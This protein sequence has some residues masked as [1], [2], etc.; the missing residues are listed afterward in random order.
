[1]IDPMTGRNVTSGF[2]W[3]RTARE[4]YDMFQLKLNLQHDCYGW[5]RIGRTFD[6][7]QTFYRG[8][9][10]EVLSGYVDGKQLAEIRLDELTRAEKATDALIFEFADAISISDYL[11]DEPK[12]EL[13][14]VREASAVAAAPDGFVS[15]GFEPTW[16]P[17]EFS[18]LCD[19]LFL[20]RWHGADPDGVL[21]A[22]HFKRLNRNGLF[23]APG[24]A[25]E[26][27]S[28]YLSFEWAE[29]PLSDTPDECGAYVIVEVFA[30]T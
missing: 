10:R 25:S 23:W 21:L 20:P 26:F 11:S 2:F 30:P 7:V 18:A 22:E 17:G 24:H 6:E 28:H 16:F 13:I 14:W 12:Y 3:V 5:P 19:S 9:N 27:L 8:T 1:M 15:C 29:Q 4:L